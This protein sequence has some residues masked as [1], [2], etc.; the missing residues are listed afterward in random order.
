MGLNPCGEIYLKPKQFCNLTSIVIRPNDTMKTLSKKM[1]IATILGTYQATL[2]N[3]GYL[4]KKWK[5]NCEEERLLGVSL[6]GY[7]DNKLIRN[8]KNLK[9]LKNI[10]V[11]D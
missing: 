3:F 8:D 7:Y 1:E 2:T 10:S 11:K 5:T 4:S 9:D 6:T